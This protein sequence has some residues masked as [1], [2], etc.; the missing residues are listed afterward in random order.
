MKKFVLLF[1]IVVC[2]FSVCACNNNTVVENKTEIC[3]FVKEIKDNV[4][5]VDIAEFITT[6]DTDR[7][8]EL[9]LTNFDMPNGYYINNTEIELKE[10][11]LTKDTVYNFIDWKNDFVEKGADREFSTKNK[12]DF[13]KYL[14]TYENSQPQ[15]PFFFD[16]ADNEVISITEKPMM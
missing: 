5:V 1:L 7:V 16:I 4:I 12:D 6:E 14:N 3:A 2:M 15:M 11:K 9:K 13:V 8:A 10:Y